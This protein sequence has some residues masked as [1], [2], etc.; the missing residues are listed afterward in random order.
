MLLT[1]G[2]FAI[3][4]IGT[5]SSLT[6]HDAKHHYVVEAVSE[7]G[8]NL[9]YTKSVDYNFGSN[10][11]FMAQVKGTDY[12]LTSNLSKGIIAHAGFGPQIGD[13]VSLYLYDSVKRE[14]N[15]F[16]VSPSAV[17]RNLEAIKY[18]I[19]SDFKRVGGVHKVADGLV[20]SSGNVRNTFVYFLNLKSRKFEKHKVLARGERV[21]DVSQSEQG[22]KFLVS[23]LD[24]SRISI[25]KVSKHKKTLSTV[26]YAHD[27]P[28][29]NAILLNSNAGREKALIEEV[30][31][32]LFSFN[33]GSKYSE[34]VFSSSEKEPSS[35]ELFSLDS[36][37][38]KD[39]LQ[40]VLQC[41][42]KVFWTNQSK[43]KIEIG[44]TVLPPKALSWSE[45]S[46]PVRSF[47]RTKQDG[48]L[49]LTVNFSKDIDG[50]Y[51]NGFT[52]IDVNE[53]C[54]D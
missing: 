8:E 34:V 49:Q 23:G 14:L 54:A 40:G 32:G 3:S 26:S 46:L 47:L 39:A 41:N 29:T 6:K 27:R 52:T 43:K 21:L 4:S 10:I 53:T 13:R 30:V 15:V 7:F 38:N 31:S 17:S 45:E 28:I 11:K 1:F 18:S 48:I 44:S 36:V 37:R 22:Y 19:P 2:V 35:K 42:E 33:Y 25:K 16:D 5:A 50:Y 12:E 20:I 9:I 24:E 51:N